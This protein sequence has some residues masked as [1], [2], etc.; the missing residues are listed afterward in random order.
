MRVLYA[1]H[2]IGIIT[3]ITIIIVIIIIIGSIIVLDLAYDV[4]VVYTIVTI[5]RR[6]RYGSRTFPIK[7]QLI[8]A[9][10]TLIILLY[11]T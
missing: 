3:I 1:Q 11:F 7:C 6:R 2:F 9:P 4:R 5:T 10:T 8:A